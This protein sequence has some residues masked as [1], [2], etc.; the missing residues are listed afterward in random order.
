MLSFILTMSACPCWFSSYSVNYQFLLWSSLLL[1]TTVMYKD[2]CFQSNCKF[3]T[4]F[5]YSVFVRCVLVEVVQVIHALV[6]G[7]ISVKK[8][9]YRFFFFLVFS[10]Q[11]R[12]GYFRVLL[13]SDFDWWKFSLSSLF[14]RRLETWWCLIFA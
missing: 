6:D 12:T 11:L 13:F 4:N 1:I 14:L 7:F 3:V 5:G 9:I 2:L 8:Q 10:F